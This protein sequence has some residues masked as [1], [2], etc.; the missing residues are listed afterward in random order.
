M[1]G[2]VPPRIWTVNRGEP[3][4][5]L[6]PDR[7]SAEFRNVRIKSVKT[8][9]QCTSVLLTKASFVLSGDHDG[10]LIVPCPPYT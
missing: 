3:M 2:A 9:R 4:A 6:A 7:A 10:T 1:R 5:F 8:D